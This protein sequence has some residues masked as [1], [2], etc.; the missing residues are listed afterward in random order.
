MLGT[1]VGPDAVAMAKDKLIRRF[2]AFA[3][4]TVVDLAT[5]EIHR[6][7]GRVMLGGIFASWMHQQ[8][9]VAL[10]EVRPAG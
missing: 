9:S 7:E 10:P 6:H 1:Q 5:G 3:W 2:S 8:I 4:P